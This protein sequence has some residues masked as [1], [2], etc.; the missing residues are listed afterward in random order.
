MTPEER[1]AF[2]RQL[3][4]TLEA[5]KDPN[6]IAPTLR[7]SIESVMDAKL[8]EIKATADEIMTIKVEKATGVKVQRPSGQR[9]I[10]L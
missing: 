9:K 1:K 8:K 4:K 6:R 7:E 10:D 3:K 2:R 5:Y